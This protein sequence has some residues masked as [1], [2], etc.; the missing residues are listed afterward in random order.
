MDLT[1]RLLIVAGIHKSPVAWGLLPVM[2]MVFP[3]VEYNNSAF[4][5]AGRM[6]SSSSRIHPLDLWK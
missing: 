3:E 4:R 5:D 6:S 1:A 2:V